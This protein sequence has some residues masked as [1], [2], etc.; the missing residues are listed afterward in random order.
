MDNNKKLLQGLLKADGINPAGATESEHIAFGKMLDEQSKPKQS[1][2][3]SRP[4]IWRI[5]MQN[6]MVRFGAAVAVVIAVVI[7]LQLNHGSIDGATIAFAQITEAM[8]HVDW[9]HLK[10]IGLPSGPSGPDEL[11]VG[12]N[13]RITFGRWNN[14]G[15]VTFLDMRNHKM[16]EYIPET[17]TITIDY[18]GEDKFPE[19]INTPVAIFENMYKMLEEQGAKR[20]INNGK[21]KGSDV[22]IQEI[23]HHIEKLD[24]K[25]TLYV[26]TDSKLLLGADVEVNDTEGNMVVDGK[27]TFDY[28]ETGPEDIYALGV[29]RTAKIVD[30]TDV[31]VENLP[32]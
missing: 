13:D 18:A 11:W 3:G 15:K 14:T 26:E 12:F 4:D 23:S 21:Y 7:G 5:I 8:K 27:M 10:C 20:I 1:K 31:A 2:P 19:H 9:M 17:Q 30:K 29:P 32:K 25:L 24:H 16:Y 28:P 6:R 22:Q